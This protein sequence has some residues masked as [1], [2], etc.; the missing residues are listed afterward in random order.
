MG[1]RTTPDAFIFSSLTQGDEAPD[2]VTGQKL[3]S[4]PTAL[5]VSTLM[6][7]VVSKDLLNSWIATNA[8]NSDKVLANK[9]ADL[10]T[11]FDSVS[12][13]QWTQNIY[14][15]WLH[16]IKSLFNSE[17]DK[18]GYPM[19][20]KTA[21]WN[22]KSTQ[23]FLGSWTELKH[24]TLLY[25]KQSYAELGAGPERKWRYLRFQRLC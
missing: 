20:M 13:D 2:P 3:P 9:I 8:P 25:A 15:S 14:W 6:G 19:F 11:Y 12:E 21:G 23:S 18:T 10:Q 1:Q 17:K 5:M 24:D 16:T 22:T 7:D 4:T